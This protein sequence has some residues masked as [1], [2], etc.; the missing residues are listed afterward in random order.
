MHALK[1]IAHAVLLTVVESAMAQG[2]TAPADRPPLVSKVAFESAAPEAP[3]LVDFKQ[4][5][6]LVQKNNLALAA[7]KSQIDIADAQIA[8]AAL[9]PDPTFTTGLS[10]YEM[11]KDKLPTISTFAVNFTIEGGRKREVRTDAARADKARAEADFVRQIVAV[12]L[13]AANAYIDHLRAK[14]M[15]KLWE[16]SLSLLEQLEQHNQKRRD[17]PDVVSQVQ[18]HAEKLRAQ[19]ELDAATADIYIASRAML[20]FAQ[21]G[22]ADLKRP[23]DGSGSL[24]LAVLEGYQTKV[25]DGAR[26]DVVAAQKAFEAA[27]RREDLSRENRSLDMNF[28]VGVNH[29]RAGEYLSTPFPQSNSLIALLTVPI[30]F[31]LRQDGDLRAASAATTQAMKQYQDLLQRSGLEAE[32][33]RARYAAALSQM[34]KYRSSS[35]MTSTALRS[36]ADLYFANKSE[37]SDV[38][39]LI[40]LNNESN[41]LRVEAQASHARSMAVLLSQARELPAMHFDRE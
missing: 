22:T 38:I 30:P 2:A 21:S 34:Q 18:L 39:V 11:S 23:F 35:E 29:A 36:H 33:A 26:E 15:Q 13:D 37:L 3:A 7:Q 4:Y 16:T 9:F 19:A 32:Q 14:V 8:L 20:A 5:L 25:R 24:E 17:K 1:Y 10:A 12:Q 31:S 28:N 41:T 6:Q 40:K 27:S